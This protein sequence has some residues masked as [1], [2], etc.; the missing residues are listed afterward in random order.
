[1][2]INLSAG[3][4]WRIQRRFLDNVECHCHLHSDDTFSSILSAC[5][6]EAVQSKIRK[7]FYSRILKIRFFFTLFR[8]SY[9]V[10]HSPIPASLILWNW[11]IEMIFTLFDIFFCFKSG[12]SFF[13]V[14]LTWSSKIICTQICI[15]GKF[16][17]SFLVMVPNFRCGCF[18]LL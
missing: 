4:R 8:I 10:Q 15:S 9:L 12:Q 7:I 17:S 3:P 6:M 18:S 2:I 13:I 5:M 11:N 16:Y 14:P 1:M